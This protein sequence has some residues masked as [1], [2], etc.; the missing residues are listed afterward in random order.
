MSTFPMWYTN[1]GLK[2]LRR[3][4]QKNG[5]NKTKDNKIVGKV[6]Q[7]MTVLVSVIRQEIRF[8]FKTVILERERRE[9][10]A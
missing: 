9:I 4:L 1:G 7:G 6:A 8:P 10:Y 3:T 2:M 5:K